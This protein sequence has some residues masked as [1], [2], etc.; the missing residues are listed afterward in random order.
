MRWRHIK[1]L[2]HQT[3]IWIIVL[4]TEVM[5]WGTRQSPSF[6]A[7]DSVNVHLMHLLA[8]VILIWRD[9]GYR[10]KYVRNTGIIQLTV[11]NIDSEKDPHGCNECSKCKQKWDQQPYSSTCENNA[12]LHIIQRIWAQLSTGVPSTLHP[13]TNYLI[14]SD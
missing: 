13:E 6:V 11:H 4:C 5:P 7:K 8:S 12:L 1:N 2:Q 9:I 10:A 14:L 3:T